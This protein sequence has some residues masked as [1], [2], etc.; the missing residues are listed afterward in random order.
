MNGIAQAIRDSIDVQAGLPKPG[1]ASGAKALAASTIGSSLVFLS[2]SVISVALPAIRDG[3]HFSA[4]DLQWTLNAELLP[5]AALSMTGGALGDRYGRRNVFLAGGALFLFASLLAGFAN[6]LS[7][8]LSARFLQGLAEALILPNGL[9]IVG[10]AYSLDKKSRAIGI[11]SGSIAVISAV[12]P[13]VAGFLLD[14]LDWR[15]AFFI[16][17]PLAALGLLMTWFWVPLDPVRKSGNID[18]G[19]AILSAVALGSLGW[20]LT[21]ASNRAGL[22]P[23]VIV[24]FAFCIVASI[25]LVRLERRR[26]DNAMLPSTLF[27]SRTLMG[28]NLYT[29]LLYGAFAVLLTMIPY[30]MIRGSGMPASVAGTAFIPLQILMAAISPL[31]PLVCARI[32]HRAPLAI[33]AVITAAGCA[34][35]LRI[36]PEMGYWLGYFPPILMMSIGMSFAVAPLTTLVLTSVDDKYAGTASGFNGAVSRAGSLVA[37]AL[38]GGLLSGVGEVSIAHMHMAM[39]CC[40]MA[41][42]AAAAAIQLLVPDPLAA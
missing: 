4:A 1:T 17:V 26:G 9:T 38:L 39:L 12:G 8:M 18:I 34:L 14:H 15:V 37:I 23:T 22:S 27:G 13:A 10:Q 30:T 29:A 36:T 33:G 16:N 41:C 28:I 25:L 20:S 7:T 3:L 31:A 35:M 24:G 32:G 42:L 11:W 21:D 6:G 2:G 40:A 5:L 19:A